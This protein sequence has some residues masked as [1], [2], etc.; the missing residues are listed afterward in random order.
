[1]APD[2]AGALSEIEQGAPLTADSHQP[3][4]ALASQTPCDRA[5]LLY[6]IVGGPYRAIQ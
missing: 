3:Y 4:H 6:A 1:M 5:N 2:S